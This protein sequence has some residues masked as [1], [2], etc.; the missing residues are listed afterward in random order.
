VRVTGGDLAL[1][2]TDAQVDELREQLVVGPS[3]ESPEGRGMFLT[4]K[5]AAERLGFSP[6]YVREHAVELGGVKMGDGPKARW[7][8]DPATLKGSGESPAPMALPAVTPP[9][10]R[11]PQRAGHGQL[12]QVRR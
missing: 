3:V 5:Q 11:A 2:L 8:F 7:R 9:R 6:E 10:R 1:D 12:L 4:T